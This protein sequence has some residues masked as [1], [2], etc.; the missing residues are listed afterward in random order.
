[1]VVCVGP[2]PFH[3]TQAQYLVMWQ[4]AI[5]L[6]SP[7]RFRKFRI[8]LHI[9]HCALHTPHFTLRPQHSPLHTLHSTVVF[10]PGLADDAL[11]LGPVIRINR[12]LT[13]RIE[14]SGSNCTVK[15]RGNEPNKQNRKK[16]RNQ[17]PRTTRKS[18][19]QICVSPRKKRRNNRRTGPR[20]AKNV[21]CRVAGLGFFFG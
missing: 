6:T 3:A 7:T 14:R 1:M 8:P 10:F 11:R 21:Q 9:V 5:D 20:S 2:W 13:K 16:T 18:P 4:L 19:S 12:E 17:Q 15:N